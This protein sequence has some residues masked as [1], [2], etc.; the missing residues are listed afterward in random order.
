MPGSVV[1]SIMRAIMLIAWASQ[2]TIRAANT[3]PKDCLKKNGAVKTLKR[4]AMA[5]IINSVPKPA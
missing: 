1:R 4:A 3:P 2:T 5:T